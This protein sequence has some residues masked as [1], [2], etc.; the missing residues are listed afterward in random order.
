MKTDQESYLLTFLAN[1]LKGGSQKETRKIY[2]CKNVNF[3][4]PWDIV[5]LLSLF[6]LRG[7]WFLFE[8]P[9]RQI[10]ND[11][12][13]MLRASHWDYV[14]SVCWFFSSTFV[15]HRLESEVEQANTR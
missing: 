13:K 2:K 9:L 1:F 4:F 5:C 10:G 7:A 3:P 6:A 11:G 12:Q 8:P 14:V 15:S